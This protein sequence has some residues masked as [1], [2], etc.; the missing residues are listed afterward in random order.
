MY[1]TKVLIE[2]IGKETFNDGFSDKNGQPADGLS[3]IFP[4][5]HLDDENPFM[6]IGTGFFIANNGLFATAKHVLLNNVRAPVKSHT[7]T[8]VCRTV[9]TRK[10]LAKVIVH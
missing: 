6:P 2:E 9:G 1:L 5:V 8:G 3:A 10:I 7:L 4:I